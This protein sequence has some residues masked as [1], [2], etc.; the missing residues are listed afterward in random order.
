MKIDS[1]VNRL[2]G[3]SGIKS[4]SFRTQNQILS[5][6]AKYG[7][8][9]L[10]KIS[11]KPRDPSIAG[12]FSQKWEIDILIILNPK[13]SAPLGNLLHLQEGFQEILARSRGF[14]EI[15]PWGYLSYLLYTTFKI[16]IRLLGLK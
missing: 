8:L 1:H 3:L 7:L 15:F 10:V 16:L 11:F 2:R 13:K 14:W 12:W 6:V 5:K 9:C 4:N